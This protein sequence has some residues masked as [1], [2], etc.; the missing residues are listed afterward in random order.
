MAG[1]VEVV[2]KMDAPTLDYHRVNVT[3]LHNQCGGRSCLRVCADNVCRKRR[4]LE[5]YPNDAPRAQR[6]RTA[7]RVCAFEG[8]L[9]Y[10][11]AYLKTRRTALFPPSFLQRSRPDQGDNSEDSEDDNV[12]LVSRTPSPPPGDGIDIDKYDEHIHRAPREVITVETKIKSTNK[13]FSMLAKL[14]WSEGQPL[15]LSGDGEPSC[16]T[17]GLTDGALH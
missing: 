16:P 6:R 15:G 11:L 4:P 13:G 9:P 14:G 2:V 3:C 12:S 7:G 5:Q 1:D 10:S 17:F 8:T